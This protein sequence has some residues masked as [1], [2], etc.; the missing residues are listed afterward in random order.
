MIVRATQQQKFLVAGNHKG[1]LEIKPFPCDKDLLS[2]R[3]CVYYGHAA[4]II[5]IALDGEDN[6]VSAA[7]GE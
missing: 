7:N 5:S 3:R 1:E 4:P 2:S 6:I